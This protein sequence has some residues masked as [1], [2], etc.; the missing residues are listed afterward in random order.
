MEIG[1]KE[2]ESGDLNDRLFAVERGFQTVEATVL[3]GYMLSLFYS[4]K[5]S[6][7]S[8]QFIYTK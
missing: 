2:I 5:I 8:A 1:D 3:D 6:E 7:S 4:R